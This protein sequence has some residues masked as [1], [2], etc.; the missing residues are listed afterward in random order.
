MNGSDA[1]ASQGPRYL[2]Y[3]LGPSAPARHLSVEA[4]LLPWSVPDELKAL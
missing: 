4:K 2:S 1:A 3:M